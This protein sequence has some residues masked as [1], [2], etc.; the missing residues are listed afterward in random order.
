MA[1]FLSGG[2]PPKRSS[3]T[4]SEKKL[5]ITTRYP[6]SRRFSL[7]WLLAFK[8]SFAWLVCRVV[9]LFTPREKPLQTKTNYCT[10]H[11][12]HANNFVKAKSHAREKLL[13][14]VGRHRK[15]FTSSPALRMA[16]FITQKYFTCIEK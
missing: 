14:P 8:E 12:S 5:L 4:T 9:G 1:L 10:R 15:I 2:Q 11:T 16:V 13:Q 6:A 7:A 3:R